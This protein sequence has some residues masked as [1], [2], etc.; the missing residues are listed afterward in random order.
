MATETQPYAHLPDLEKVSLRATEFLSAGPTS[1]QEASKGL[2]IDILATRDGDFF[3]M[4]EMDDLLAMRPMDVPSR[5]FSLAN[6]R[7]DDL[8][9][10]LP[11]LKGRDR[12]VVTKLLP[13]LDSL[14]GFLTK[15]AARA[16][17]SRAPPG[18]PYSLDVG[19][20]DRFQGLALHVR[21]HVGHDVAAALDHAEDDGL[22]SARFP[23]PLP[24]FLRVGT[25]NSLRKR[26]PE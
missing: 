12:P 22:I 7:I 18:R 23:R 24:C 5:V 13:N 19:P 6:P 9:E 3:P 11:S 10:T 26:S 1:E 2:L 17:R 15:G 25:R 16:R 14:I 21:D 4:E 20:H 8:M